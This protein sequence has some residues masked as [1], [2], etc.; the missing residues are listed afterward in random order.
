MGKIKVV[1]T[2]YIEPDL[3]WEEKELSKYSDIEF[4]HYQLKHKTRDEVLE[5]ISDADVVVVNMV[6]M[7]RET[8]KGLKKCKLIIRHGIGYDNVDVAACSEFG[9]TLAN[10]PDYCVEEVAEQAVMLIFA[11]SRKIHYQKK[12]LIDSAKRGEWDFSDLYPIFKLRGKT[13]GLVGCGRIGSTVLEMMRGVGMNV[14]VCDPYLTEERKKE[15]NIVHEDLNTILKESDVVSVHC[16]LNDETKEMF[17]SEQFKLMKPSS[18]FINTARGGIVKTEDLVRAV[19]E[20]VIA[21]A[22]IDVYTGKEPPPADSPLFKMDN[23]ILSPHIS[24]YSEES[25]WSIRFKI[26]DDILRFYQGEKPRFIVNK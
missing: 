20:R 24:W 18:Y 14:R 9:I 3:N 25:G 1:V 4:S 2:D 6:P 17:K 5:K 7:D 12:V 8:L 19:E 21:G 10:I 16:L 23:I 11:C 15:L 26:V 13:L 22:G